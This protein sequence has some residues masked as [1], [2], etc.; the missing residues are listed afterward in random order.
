[1]KRIIAFACFMLLLACTGNGQVFSNNYHSKTYIPQLN[2][3]RAT[4]YTVDSP[5]W[6]YAHHP[7]IAY[8][9]GK[10]IAVFSNGITGEDSARQRIMTSTS[11]DFYSWTTPQILQAPADT[12]HELTSGGLLVANDSL[13]VSYYTENDSLDPREYVNLFAVTSQN[14]TSWSS[15][16]DLG[17]RVFPSHKPTR[18]SSGRLILTGNRDFYYTDSAKGISGWVRSDR[19]DFLPGQSATLV[20]G[21]IIEHPDSIY[22]LF[23]D[24]GKML[25]WQESSADGQSWSAPRKTSFTDNN[26]KFHLGKLPDGRYYYIGSP[27]T[28]SR[29]ARTPLVLSVSTDGFTFNKHYIIAN[30]DYKIQF[31][32]GRWKS[33]DFGYPYSIVHNDSLYVIVSRE[34]EKIEVIRFPLSFDTLTAPDLSP[35]DLSLSPQLDGTALPTAKGWIAGTITNPASGSITPGGELR[36]NCLANQSYTFQVTPSTDTVFNPTGNYT[37]EFRLKVVANNGRGIDIYT[38]DRV[39]DNKLLCIDTARVYINGGATLYTL[40]ATEYHTY[41]LAVERGSKNVHLYIDGEFITTY[42]RPVNKSTPQLLFGKSN[43]AATTEGYLDYLAY[44]LTGAYKPESVSLLSQAGKEE[45]VA[46]VNSKKLS[47]SDK[48]QVYPNPV[49]AGSR[50]TIS[51]HD[52]SKYKGNI[53]LELKDANGRILNS[54]QCA[55]CLNKAL[56]LQ[57]P[58]S[59]SKGFYFLSITGNS[60]NEIKKIL[61]E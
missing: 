56:N 23:R 60:V 48:L 15:P 38:R 32:Q 3:E 26:T 36:I 19:S 30:D 39:A 49:K 17:I 14:G 43:A 55:D 18:L 2:V 21:A 42:N 50:I 28:I 4:I 24:S 9:N 20:E 59:A 35:K 1:M 6:K 58:A 40:D 47:V 8:F 5:N 46:N 16:I 51:A 31:P 29:G 54:T 45:V 57:V 44:D 27:D 12:T 61:V 7:S 34:K 11:T 13:L 22:T 53:T 25:L 10:F 41:R 33:G 52:L 37:I